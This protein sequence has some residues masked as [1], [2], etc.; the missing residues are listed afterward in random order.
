MDV[1]L[2]S[3]PH[4]DVT[5]PL[6]TRRWERLGFSHLNVDSCH[7]FITLK[8]IRTSSSTQL[9]FHQAGI[10]APYSIQQSIS[11]S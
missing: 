2:G 10:D 6:V 5:C 3:G 1:A 8:L 4:T 7:K 9:I 11:I